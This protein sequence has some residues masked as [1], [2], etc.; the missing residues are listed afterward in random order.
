M[1]ALGKTVQLLPNEWGQETRYKRCQE[2]KLKTQPKNR[3][4]RYPISRY[5]NTR[6]A[7]WT[8]ISG[9]KVY[10]PEPGTIRRFVQPWMADRQAAS[11]FLTIRCHTGL[12]GRTGFVEAQVA[13]PICLLYNVVGLSRMDIDLCALVSER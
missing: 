11:V 9:E 6:F 12:G 4:E 10:Q 2:S 5:L 1:S 7:N 8:S 3:A 13:P